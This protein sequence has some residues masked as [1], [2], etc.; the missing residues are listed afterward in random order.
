[1]GG[2]W[3]WTGGWLIAAAAMLMGLGG[4]G[5]GAHR[6][7]DSLGPGAGKHSWWPLADEPEPAA[8]DP[9][10]V[11]PPKAIWVVRHAYQSPKEIAAVM[12][13][14]RSAGFNTVLFQVRG[15]G[16]AY[17]RSRIEPF[18]EDYG[19]RDPGFDPLTVACREA[20]RRG[21]ALHAWVNVIPAW[22]GQQP[23]PWPEHVYHRH[24]EWLWYDQNG[25]RQPLG[26]Y[27]SLNPCLPEVRQYLVGVFEEIVRNYA[28]DGLHLDYIRFPSEVSPR[29]ADYPYDART[30]RLYRA[31]TGLTPR[32]NKASWIRWRTAQVTQ[33]VRDI[34]A[35]TRRA[36]P[37][38]K[39]TAAVWADMD[40]VRRDYFQDGAAWIREGLVDLAFTMNYTTGTWAFR[41]RQEVWRRAA[42]SRPVAVG[43]QAAQRPGDRTT[44][45]QVRLGRAWGGGVAVFSDQIIFADPQ[46]ASAWAEALR[47]ILLGP[48]PSL[49]R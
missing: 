8:P 30:L 49:T 35:A 13:T 47:P 25:R 1:M 5:P 28:V 6:G 39:L 43:I 21:M 4:C 37:D 18:S 27:V 41:Q 29:G 42:G 15:N 12:E 32:Q 26:W 40:G 44:L 38:L 19:G 16:T 48:Q 17:Y 24:P 2:R 45:E 33:L 22:R 23:P 46:R 10:T 36:R 11:W 9:R 31:A 7:Q 20:H 34:R 3:G 14:C